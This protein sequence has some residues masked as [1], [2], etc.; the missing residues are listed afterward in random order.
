MVRGMVVGVL[1]ASTSGL[2]GQAATVRPKFDSF[3]VATVKP[4]DPEERSRLLMMQGDNRFIGKNYTVKLMIA[5][6][7]DLNPKAISGGP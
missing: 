4:S 5:A 7:Y 2:F 3:E 6:A 1:L